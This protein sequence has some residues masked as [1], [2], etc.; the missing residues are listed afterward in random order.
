[1]QV[2]DEEQNQ[3]THVCMSYWKYHDIR[4]RDHAW[5]N[6]WG[7]KHLVECQRVL[8]GW[9]KVKTT[10]DADTGA[11]CTRWEVRSELRFDNAWSPVWSCNSSGHSY[12]ISVLKDMSF[13][14]PPDYPHLRALY[15]P[16]GLVNKGDTLV[17]VRRPGKEHMREETDLPKVKLSILLCRHA[18][19]LYERRIWAS[20]AFCSFV[21]QDTAFAV[22][23]RWGRSAGKPY[24]SNTNEGWSVIQMPS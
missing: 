20:V 6:R 15:L 10:H 4:N 1:M 8:L 22:Q 13:R 7:I 14:L 23:P 19:D 17:T 24:A 3:C 5:L 11:E 18:F 9:L 16:F 21:T 2:G 12:Q